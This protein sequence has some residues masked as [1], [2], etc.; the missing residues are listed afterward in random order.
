MYRT[1]Y[2]C[3]IKS[4]VKLLSFAYFPVLPEGTNILSFCDSVVTILLVIPAFYI[5][6]ED[7]FD[8]LKLAIFCFLLTSVSRYFNG[9]ENIFSNLFD[10][11]FS[12]VPIFFN[13]LSFYF[14]INYFSQSILRFL[15]SNYKKSFKNF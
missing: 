10:F 13:Y 5:I 12:F 8:Y 7:D 11:L 4:S 14:L 9:F 15:L 3:F 2:F 1:P 6:Q